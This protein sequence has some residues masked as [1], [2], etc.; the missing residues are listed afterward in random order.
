M[1][2]RYVP[3]H[4]IAG[5][6]GASRHTERLAEATGKPAASDD[7]TF[8]GRAGLIENTP[9]FKNLRADMKAYWVVPLLLFMAGC[10]QEPPLPPPSGPAFLPGVN[11]QINPDTAVN[12]GMADVLAHLRQR[13][14]SAN[15]F[16]GI[17]GLD[18]LYPDTLRLD[19][20]IDCDIHDSKGAAQALGSVLAAGTLFIVPHGETC[21]YSLDVRLFAGPKLV[22]SDKI[23]RPYTKT[24]G[25]AADSQLTGDE[26]GA[27]AVFDAFEAQWRAHPPL[28][29]VE[30]GE[31]KKV[32]L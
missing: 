12:Y 3:S 30:P 4:A 19:F 15:M 27:D 18:G 23:T 2:I 26:H 17:G 7:R 5:S 32:S 25:L 29:P 13:V 24:I 6:H 14:I 28:K 20:G 1:P 21:L 8:D 10:Q 22:V 11:L 31:P 9:D 16:A